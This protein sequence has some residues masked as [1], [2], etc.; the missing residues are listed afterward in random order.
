MEKKCLDLWKDGLHNLR[1]PHSCLQMSIMERLERLRIRGKSVCNKG[2]E[3]QG[4][5]EECVYI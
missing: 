2:Q 1:G 4:M 5:G 3:R